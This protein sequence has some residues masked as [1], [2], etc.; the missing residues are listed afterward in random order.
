MAAAAA[1]RNL[2]IV[3]GGDLAGQFHDHGV[4][5]WRRG[6]DCA[7]PSWA[8]ALRASL[9]LSKFVPDEFVKPTRTWVLIPP[10]RKHV[11]DEQACELR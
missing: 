7:S 11:S 8:R 3:G 10:S 2:W 4:F 9:Q 6:W 1:G 5:E